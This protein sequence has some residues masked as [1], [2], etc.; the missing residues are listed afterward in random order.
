[1]L[2][3]DEV[4]ERVAESLFALKRQRAVNAYLD[5]LRARAVVEGA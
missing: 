3:F 5:M 2:P 4:R 1:M